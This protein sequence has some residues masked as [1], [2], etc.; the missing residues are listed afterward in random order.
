MINIDTTLI[1]VAIQ[2]NTISKTNPI[3]RAS[4]TE[5][6]LLTN[7]TNTIQKTKLEEA[8][9]AWKNKHDQVDDVAVIG[10]KVI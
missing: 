5:N 1:G 2:N 3:S 9:V 6:T 4:G 7:K 10:V 8:F